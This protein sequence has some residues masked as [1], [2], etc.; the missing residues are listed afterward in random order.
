VTIVPNPAKD[1]LQIS[2]ASKSDVLKLVNLYGQEVFSTIL[3]DATVQLPKSMTPGLYYAIVVSP[4]GNT[5][6]KLL[7]TQ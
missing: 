7:I 3:T 4:H 5:Y 6:L 1:Y 2:G